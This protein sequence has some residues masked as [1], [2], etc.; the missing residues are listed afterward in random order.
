MMA[1]QFARVDPTGILEAASFGI[2]LTK[3]VDFVES[4][5]LL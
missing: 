3:H 4:I 1:L 2:H 5:H